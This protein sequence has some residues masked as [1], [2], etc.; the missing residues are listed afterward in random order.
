MFNVYACSLTRLLVWSFVCCFPAIDRNNLVE[1]L[2][3]M[4]PK[5]PEVM[6]FLSRAQYLGNPI[7]T[8]MHA[9]SA[10]RSSLANPPLATPPSSPRANSMLAEPADAPQ[11][12]PTSRTPVAPVSL[13]R[14]Q[15]FRSRTPDGTT[16]RC[17]LGL[18][19]EFPV[20][21]D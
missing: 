21:L 12:P 3:A 13:H 20:F 7:A 16:Q 4:D 5:P 14:T 8:L 17:V 1:R 2:S 9:R 10:P 15:P 6:A 19:F 11:T 18:D